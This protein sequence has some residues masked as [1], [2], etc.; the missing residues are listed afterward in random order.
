[1]GAPVPPLKNLICCCVALFK[2]IVDAELDKVIELP[3]NVGD[4]VVPVTVKLPFTVSPVIV[5]PL[6]G[7]VNPVIDDRVPVPNNVIVPLEYVPPVAALDT[8]APPFV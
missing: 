7:V 2:L 8:P 3:V 1:M 4:D 6:N 5:P